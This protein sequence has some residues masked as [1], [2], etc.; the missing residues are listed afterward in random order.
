[1][2]FAGDFNAHHTSW[3]CDSTNSRGRDILEIADDNDLVLLNNGEATT[4]GSLSWRPNALDLTFVSPSLS[5]CCDW[6][7]LN[8]PLGSYHLPVIIKVLICNNVNNNVQA[9][10]IDSKHLPIY[11]N[12]KSVDWK[13]YTQIADSLLSNF[14]VQNY[15]PLEAYEEFCKRLHSAVERSLPSKTTSPSSHSSN[16]IRK[17]LKKI[18][19]PWWNKKCSEA[20]L[21][22]KLAYIHFK[23]N[24]STESYIEF[25]RLQAL[26]KLT[27]KTERSNSWVELCSSFHRC[28]PLSSIWKYMRKF[29]K[30]YSYSNKD[31]SWILQFL[32]KYTLDYVNNK[33]EFS[34]S[35]TTNSSDSF[36]VKP[37][38]FQ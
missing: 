5:L 4:V 34:T 22:S 20:V 16:S 25:K 18:S 8:D 31:D 21:N 23:N 12:F 2:I 28:T 36:M 7:V 14:Q 19:L 15:T 13:M 38:T 1:M 10:S 11:S 9:C 32:Q 37:F 35:N 17:P 3:G 24:P 26:K 30:T 6:S 27:L 33:L 29:N